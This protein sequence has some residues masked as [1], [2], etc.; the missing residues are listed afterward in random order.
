[1]RLVHV[2]EAQ[3]REVVSDLRSIRVRTEITDEGSILSCLGPALRNF[4]IGKQCDSALLVNCV[5]GGSEP[6]FSYSG[7]NSRVATLLVSTSGWL[8][9][10]MPNRESATAAIFQRKNS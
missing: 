4:L 8:N 9:A 6:V 7:T 2:D 3:Q 5:S 10:L 1:M